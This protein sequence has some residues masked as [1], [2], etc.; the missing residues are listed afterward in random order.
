MTITLLKRDGI[1]C[2]ILW[3]PK[4]L[5]CTCHHYP[6]VPENN[7]HSNSD[8]SLTTSNEPLFLELYI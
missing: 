5:S 3:V 4:S 2:L 6:S 7:D 1:F 8:Y